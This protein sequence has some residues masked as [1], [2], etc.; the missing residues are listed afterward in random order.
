MTASDACHPGLP[1]S[2]RFRSPRRTE[3]PLTICAPSSRSIQPD[4]SASNGACS[5]TRRRS[6]VEI[7]L[8]LA[9]DAKIPQENPQTG[10]QFFNSASAALAGAF[11]KI[12]AHAECSDDVGGSA[13][14]LFDRGF[15]RTSIAFQ[16]LSER[17]HGWR[18][19]MPYLRDRRGTTNAN[20]HQV[21]TVTLCPEVGMV[22]VS[23]SGG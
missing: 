21:V 6:F 10:N 4:R 7:G 3:R 16:P 13:A 2:W 1:L 12:S 19:R 14:V 8:A 15:C 22:I 20:L 11:Q 18:L 9:S 5:S 23:F 17:G